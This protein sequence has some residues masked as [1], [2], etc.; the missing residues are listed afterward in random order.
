MLRALRVWIQVA[1]ALAVPEH[2]IEG[3]SLRLRS[4]FPWSSN[5]GDGESQKVEFSHAFPNQ[6]AFFF[7]RYQR[8]MLIPIVRPSQHRAPFVPDDLLRIEEHGPQEAVENFA[9]KTDAR[10]T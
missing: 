9:V 6:G 4:I 2:H 10:Q 5:S 1:A 7:C 8:F 3:R